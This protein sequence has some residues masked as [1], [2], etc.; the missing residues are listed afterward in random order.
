[1]SALHATCRQPLGPQRYVL[2]P[3]LQQQ[4]EHEHGDRHRGH[5]ERECGV[6][7]H[8]SADVERRETG[9]IAITHGVER[10]DVEPVGP[11]CRALE[12]R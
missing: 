2:A 9:L 11:G 5:G 3:T 1:M 7:A 10:V 6:Q 8:E 12:A 4:P